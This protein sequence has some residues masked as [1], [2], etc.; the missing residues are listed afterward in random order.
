MEEAVFVKGHGVGLIALVV[1]GGDGRALEQYLVVVS[2]L[3]LDALDGAAHRTHGV[4][5]AEMVARHG[6]QTLRESVAHNHVDAHGVDKLFHL[7]RHVG[8]GRGEDVGI[9]Q[10]YLLSHHAQDGLVDH[11]VFQF[12]CQRHAL[13]PTKILDVAPPTDVQGTAEDSLLQRAGSLDALFHGHIHLLPKAGHSR[14]TRGVGLPHRLL[15]LLGIGVDD[16]PGTLR[17][18][19]IGPS[20]LKN[21]GKGQEVDHLVFLAYGH[22]LVVGLQTCGILSVGE[23]HSFAVARGA[24]GVEYVADILVVGLSPQFFH[25]RL[26]RQI[27]AQ[28]DEIFKIEG[29]RV[30]SGDAYTAVEDDDALKRRAEGEDAVGLV[31]LFLLA[32]KEKAHPSVVDHILYLLFAARGIKRHRNRPHAIGAEVG[33]EILYTVLREHGDM[34][35][36]LHTQIEQGIAHLLD[37]ERE[38]VPRHVFPFQT[39]EA[40]K[41]ECC[42]V[43]IFFCL[44]VNKHRKVASCL[45]SLFC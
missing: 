30:V 4:G 18:R 16:E 8:S 23:N 17:E 28:L 26:P 31:I 33:V 21:M 14:H 3:Y 1:A 27:L 7:G 20:A 35:L 5:F 43:A 44:F 11:L 2:Y 40:A 9:F 41:R 39:A 29:C 24:A 10:S 34:V 19:Q 22:T 36:R 38:L 6:G 15:Y 32:Y 42:S 25:F 37:S 13:A 12:Q 45:H